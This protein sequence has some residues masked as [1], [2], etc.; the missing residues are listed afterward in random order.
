M[1]NIA[2]YTE[3]TKSSGGSHHQNLKLINIF[4]KY[5]HKEFNFT[6]IVTSQAQK[7]EF[8]K[9][10]LDVFLFKKNLR[11]RI[12][13]F[14]FR[15]NFFKEIY[16]KFSINSSLENFL[17]LKNFDLIFFN[18][19]YEASLLINKIN[20]IIM[21]L[22]LQHQQLSFFPE[23]KLGHDIDIRDKIIENS[24]KKSFKIFI[25]SEKDKDLLINFFNADINKII[26]QPY[27][28]NL[29]TIFEDNSEYNFE[30][31]FKDLNIPDNKDIFLYPA[32]FWAHKNH[33]YVVDV[34]MQCK[35][36]NIKKI[37]FV[38]CGFDK[39]NLNYIKKIINENNLDE[40]IRIFSFL[41]D[42]ELISLYIN[43]FGIIMPTFVGSTTIPMYEAFYFKKN[44][45]FTRGL[46]DSS[47]SNFITEIDL[48]DAN[49]FIE[50]YYEV[51]NNNIK[52]QEKLTN[53]KIFIDNHCN[54]TLIANN[55]R[56]ILKE[57]KYFKSLWS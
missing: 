54:D 56:K 23:Y 21:L 25:G 49:S 26:I 11:F 35:K 29:P 38:F 37:F 22:S 2:I 20:F 17:I 1:I 45:F 43:C 4:S 9:K 32:Q 53:A 19:P 12:E 44:I 30:K 7:E 28:F 10:N 16:K 15:F 27:V 48:N 13:Q 57:Y 40:Y 47:I 50:K 34:A 3:T 55:F 33:K 18:A 39:G 51:K 31:K 52:N 42:F 41:S 46:A 14:L 24:V 8:L 5:L 6:Y 36:K